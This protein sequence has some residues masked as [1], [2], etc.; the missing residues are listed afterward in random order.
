MKTKL[1]TK[2]LSLGL[3]L[4][5]VLAFGVQGIADALTF[6]TTRTGDFQ[7]V[8]PSDDFKITFSVSLKLS[9]AVNKSTS[10]ATSTDI[11]YAAQRRTRP[12]KSHP[13]TI[14][15]TVTTD[16]GYTEGDTHYYVVTTEA[17][18]SKTNGA[19]E[20]VEGSVVKTTNT[21]NW[22]TEDE[23]YYYNQE[24]VTITATN[25]QIKKVGSH[26]L[27]GTPN[28][29]T[30]KE[31]GKDGEKLF[32]SSMTLTLTASTPAKVIITIEDTTPRTDLP[33]DYR[34]EG[35]A[36]GSKYTSDLTFTV[37]VVNFDE[38]V[39]AS[40]D[41][42]FSITDGSAVDST[43]QAVARSLQSPQAIGFSLTGTPSTHIP[44][45]FKVEGGGQVYVREDQRA[46]DKDKKGSSKTTLETSS[47]AKVW[48][49]MRGNT[50]KVTVY[51]RGKN[52]S[53]HGK[54]II[55]IHGYAQLTVTEGNNQT[56]ARG[57][58]LEEVLGVKVTDSRNRAIRYPLIVKFPA[59]LTDN[60]G[61][62]IPFPGT[63]LFH[64]NAETL[65]TAT[66]PTA[67]TA[68]QVYT[69]SSGIAKIYYQLNDNLTNGTA[70]T[71]TPGLKHNTGVTTNFTFH[72]GTAGSERV[73]NL[74][75]VSGNP[76][77]AAVGKDV[78]KPLVVI[79]RSTAGYRIPNVVIQFT[80]G[81]GI[82]SRHG[83][84]E[85]PYI[86]NGSGND[87]TLP[88]DDTS[89]LEWG[90]IPNG[91]PNPNSG[92]Q[93]YVITGADGQAS[94]NYNV[95][96][97]TIAREVTAEVRHEPLDSDY[98]F[99][100]RRVTFNINGSS[101]TRQPTT[102]TTPTTTTPNLSIS[103]ADGE[104]AT[105][106]QVTVTA[107]DAQ[108]TAV[109]GLAITLTSLASGFTLSDAERN[110]VS[111]TA[112]TITVPTT[113]GSYTI[114]ASASGYTVAEMTIT[115]ARV[116]PGTLTLTTIGQRSGTQQQVRVTASGRTIPSAGLVVTLHGGAF[117][118]TVTIPSGS[119][120]ASKIITLPSA[121]GAHAVYASATN[122]NNSASIT[123]PVPGQTT[124]TPTTTPTT[125]AP[126]GTAESIEID[127][128]RQ[129]NGTLAAATPLRVRVLD[130]NDAGVSEV[131][132]VFRVLAPGRGTFAGARGSGRA[133]RLETDRSGT[134]R[135]NFTPTTEGDIIVEAKAAGVT[136]P[137]TF[138]I[139]VGETST[140]TTPATSPNTGETPEPR[141]TIDPEVL[142]GAAQRP[143]MLWVDGGS[144]YAL[145]GADVQE[146][147]IGV[148]N[149]QNLAVSGNKL[150]WTERTGENAGTIN[151][152]NLDGTGAKQL[153][154]IKAVP[155]GIAVDSVGKRLYWTNSHGWIQSSNLQG[156][157]RRNVARG[158]SDPTGI[159]VAAGKTVYWT[160]E[161]PSSPELLNGHT[162]QSVPG[163]S[164]A[165]SGNTLYWTAKTG[166]NA[167]TIHSV[168][169]NGTG[170][171][172][173]VSIKAVPM[174]IT[175]DPVAKRLYW[176]NSH[177]WIQSSNLQGT[178]RRNVAKGLGSPGGIAL[179]ANI[180]APATTP[181]TTSTPVSGGGS[182][183]DVNGDGTVDSKDVDAVL[184]AVSAGLTLA[185]YDVN[186]DKNVDIKDIMAVNANLTAG[187]A[188]APTLLG[189]KFTAIEIDRLQAQIDLLIA[190]GDRSP[191]AMK[192]LIY[193]Q[194]LI[195]MARPEK[196]Q[197]LANYPNPFNP[198]T[199]IP[200]ELATDTDV[201]ITIY[202]AQGVV[203]RTLQLGQQS[204]GY[205]TDR[206]RAAYWDGRN[207]LGEQVASGIYFYQ[208][209]TDAMSSLRKM[210]ILK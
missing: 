2:N 203:I 186:G 154:S 108:G 80:T 148:E 136:A 76:Q 52:P 209:E 31:T 77:S 11:D 8:L 10:K 114:Q 97:Y 65:A 197:L 205:Y 43:T 172:H 195:A 178:A 70:Y 158:L 60:N 33:T 42:V 53:T 126:G 175:V 85:G 168:N 78:A 64:N 196:T 118:Q 93:I 149:V 19:G 104:T 54:S 79:A 28:T 170:A 206:E 129:V 57:G 188:G 20:N 95:G 115:V 94:V 48:L 7:T 128:N 190:T 112:K 132:V 36:N 90:E 160:E 103:V 87:R 102:P 29:W 84:T 119:T 181:L 62:F 40:T 208:L 51:P 191:A 56:G 37:Y 123:I 166:E 171:K 163:V 89:K 67:A 113:P 139:D 135:A 30:L 23:A 194:Q 92:Q 187:A 17:D 35:D 122:Y 183:Y 44:L 46:T 145:V 200:Y 107:T 173:L 120:S 153:V 106:R 41:I 69:D 98:S 101:T 61:K 207:A 182:K 184:L 55:Y 110:A 134:A 144:L 109:S 75:I 162:G 4:A 147:A 24:Q 34:K 169:L 131:G 167:G 63:K 68:H 157:A 13:I 179:S 16:A 21:R 73:A 177:G 15:Y 5:L 137:V 1:F 99:A 124:T 81:I 189:T 105:T 156:T 143:P 86:N 50:N 176:T 180:K 25:A 59:T 164:V 116:A 161:G 130:A 88:N 38:T 9:D 152:M 27:F 47:E 117:T 74:E 125:P 146:F 91:T 22:L 174:G 202:N 133:I 100:I 96:Q 121:T 82:L 66:S 204:A 210:V 32:S 192:T 193:L 159:A 151:A 199:W 6:G 39:R 26:D 111:G 185:K 165:I 58:R 150:Y 18:V 72:T 3:V 198:E 45:V 201:R 155:K 127:G 142:M 138:I 49:D 71:I 83:S 14:S 12:T 141:R 140:P